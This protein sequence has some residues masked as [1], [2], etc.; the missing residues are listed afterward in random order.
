MC[1]VTNKL[2]SDLLK[3]CPDT[4][5]EVC[6]CK[7]LYFTA[8]LEGEFKCPNNTCVKDF[9]QCDPVVDDIDDKKGCEPGSTDPGCIS[10]A[11]VSK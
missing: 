8:C 10:A 11:A 1:N 2:D 7:F 3:H 4:W 9:K 6:Y 5:H